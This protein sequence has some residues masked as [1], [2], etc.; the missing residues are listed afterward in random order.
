V[1]GPPNGTYL[2]TGLTCAG[3]PV[4]FPSGPIASVDFII[5][6]TTGSLVTAANNGCVDTQGQVLAYPSA[7]E[8]TTLKVN[9]VCSGN[10]AA[11]GGLCTNNNTQGTLHLV[12]WTLTGTTLTYTQTSDGTDGCTNG[13]KTVY[14][15]AK[16]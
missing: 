1:S 7:G 3:S 16:Q 12:S 6:N 9:E 15:M 4:T 14:T 10:T 5:L 8:F 2:I 13:Q 11:C